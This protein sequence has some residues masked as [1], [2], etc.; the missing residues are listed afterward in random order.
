MR[1]SDWSSD[2]WSSDLDLLAQT[3]EVFA[4]SQPWIRD[5]ALSPKSVVRDMFER[6]LSFGEFVSLYSLAR[7]EGLVLRYLSDTYRAIRQTVPVEA[8]T[9]DLLA[10]IAVLG[11]L[12]RPILS[13]LVAA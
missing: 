5:F 11:E 8:Q 6:A 1:I 3:Y 4:S 9:P 10:L 12:V 2:V 7:S 13:G